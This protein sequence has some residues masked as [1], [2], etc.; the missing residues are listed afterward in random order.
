MGG[1]IGDSVWK[2]SL[3]N[4]MQRKFELHYDRD[5]GSANFVHAGNGHGSPLRSLDGA[6]QERGQRRRLYSAVYR[7]KPSRRNKITFKREEEASVADSAYLNK[8]GAR[9]D[10]EPAS[11]F[12]LLSSAPNRSSGDF[13]SCQH[14]FFSI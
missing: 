3:G 9:L 6:T 7:K 8:S 13:A 2:S 4:F 12:H 10:R 11:A 5:F 14:C 1:K